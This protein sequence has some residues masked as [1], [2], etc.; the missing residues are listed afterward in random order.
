MVVSCMD[1]CEKHEL[2]YLQRLG[3]NKTVKKL[4]HAISA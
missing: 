4:Q 2:I 1:S 3:K